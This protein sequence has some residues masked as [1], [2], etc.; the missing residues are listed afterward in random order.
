MFNS[1]NVENEKKFIGKY[2]TYGKQVLKINKIEVKVASTGSKQVVFNVEGPEITEK[3]FEGAEGAK[4]Q[5]GKI[6]TSYMKPEQEASISVTFARIADA[7]EVRATLNAVT[8]STLE[9]YVEAANKILTNKEAMFVV[10]GREYIKNDGKKGIELGF[11]KYNFVEKLG[12]EPSTIKFDKS[13]PYHFKPA[14]Q[15]DTF[16]SGNE[17]PASNITELDDLPF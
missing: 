10:S 4:G 2:I 6:T 14:V 8:A 7:L 3:G 1:S 5:V 17:I 16:T 12:T 13:S 11:P 9:E 15:P